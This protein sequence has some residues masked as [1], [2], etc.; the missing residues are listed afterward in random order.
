MTVF[1]RTESTLEKFAVGLE[2]P[3]DVGNDI[4]AVIEDSN[5]VSEVKVFLKPHSGLSTVRTEI[6]VRWR[7]LS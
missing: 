4:A 3:H 6:F 5:A 7:D 2:N 1:C